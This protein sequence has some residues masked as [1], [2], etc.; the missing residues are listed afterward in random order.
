MKIQVFDTTLRDGAQGYGISFT[1]SD[2]LHI[3]KALDALGVDFIEIG[4]F[5]LSEDRHLFDSVAKLSLTHAVPVA[6][7]ATRYPHTR[8]EENEALVRVAECPLLAVSVFGKAHLV[9]VRDILRTT[10][11]ENLMM[12]RDSIA[13][14]KAHGKAV[15]FDAEHFFNGY[16]DNA[17]YALSVLR[18]A[19]EA[20]ADTI[21]LCDTNGDMLPDIIG[22]VTERVKAEFPEASIGIHTHND[23]GMAVACTLS[24]VLAGANQ[25]QVTVSGIGERCGNANLSTVIPLLQL[26]MGYQLIPED[27]LRHLTSV[28][29]YVNE[30]ANRSFNESEPFVGG[31]A[32]THKAGMHVDAVYK[33]PASFEHIDPALVGNERNILV[34]SLSGRS[35]IHA[36]MLGFMPTLSKDSPLVPKAVERVKSLEAAGYRFEDAEGS[37][38]LR[39]REVA[40]GESV[41]RFFRLENFRVLISESRNETEPLCSAQIKIAV[42]GTEEITAAE[43]DGPVNALDLALRKALLRFYPEIASIRLCDYKVRV[44]DSGSNTASKVLVRVSTTDGTLLWRTVGVSPDI[45]DASWQALSD[46]MVYFLEKVRK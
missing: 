23:L 10:P 18:T 32:F 17:P 14:L 38:E 42:N 5:A 20:G 21:V 33:D 34:T 29:R 45:I 39:L 12:I 36:K 44:L 31:S 19:L 6:F 37:L 22:M 28:A 27:K 30:I 35:A 41:N 7:G 3:I 11:E 16:A 43:G 2:K 4:N 26:K 25:V 9:H 24:G 15:F 40:T 1:E 46:S 13:Y 8:C